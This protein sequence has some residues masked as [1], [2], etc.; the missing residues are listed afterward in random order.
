MEK[1]VESL[2]I[3]SLSRSQVSMMARDLD[4]QVE[5]F[6]TRPLDQGPYTVFRPDGR[7]LGRRRR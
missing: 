3:T 6:R 2:G 7:L 5:A 4:T 1:L